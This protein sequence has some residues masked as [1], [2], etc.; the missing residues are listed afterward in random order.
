MGSYSY[1]KLSQ[2]IQR[3]TMCLPEL[4]WRYQITLWCHERERIVLLM[5]E[6]SSSEIAM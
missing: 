5:T 1:R 6:M 4:S 3:H 2:K